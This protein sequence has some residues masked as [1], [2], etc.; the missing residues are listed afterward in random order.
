MQYRAAY[1][2]ILCCALMHMTMISS[3]IVCYHTVAKKGILT[4]QLVSQAVAYPLLGWHA[5][6]Y[7]TRYRSWVDKPVVPIVPKVVSKPCTLY[8]P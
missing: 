6:V 8:K 2:V 7:F 3:D 1:L 5:D 4:Y